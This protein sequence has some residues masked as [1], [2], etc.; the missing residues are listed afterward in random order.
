MSVGIGR[1]IGFLVEILFRL[2]CPFCFRLLIEVDSFFLPLFISL[3]VVLL[4]GGNTGDVSPTGSSIG[5][6]VVAVDEDLIEIVLFVVID[7]NEGERLVVFP[8]DIDTFALSLD[9]SILSSF[10]GQVTDTSLCFISLLGIVFLLRY[11]DTCLVMYAVRIS[12]VEI[13]SLLRYIDTCLVMYAL[14]ILVTPQ[15][16][17]DSFLRV[18]LIV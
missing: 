15:L 6:F 7:V 9:F 14:L 2:W 12:L 17:C 3:G 13:V 5:S 10:L 16:V 11:I 1:R 4:L 18:A 8:N